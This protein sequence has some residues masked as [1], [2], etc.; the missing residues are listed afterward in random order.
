MSRVD[1]GTRENV[2][3]PSLK[4]RRIAMLRRTKIADRHRIAL[5]PPTT[6]FWGILGIV[7]IFVVLGIIMVLS[8]SSVVRLQSGGSAWDYFLR[9]ILW[10]SMGAGG[11]WYAYRIPYTT[12]V[13]Q[14][15]LSLAAVAVSVANVFVFAKGEFIKGAR[16]WLE[17]FGFRFQPS[18][19]MKIVAVLFCA[20]LIAKRHRSVAIPAMVHYPLVG[21]MCVTAGLC[22]LQR[23]Y[24][25]ALIFIGTIS[26]MMV[27]SGLSWRRITATLA[28][29]AVAGWLLLQVSTRARVRLTAFLNLDETK[30]DWGYQVYQ[31]LLSMANGG[32]TGTGIGSGTAKWGYVPEAHTDFIFAVIA[33]ELGL[34]GTVLVIGGFIFLVL[35]GVR[36]ALAAPDMTSALIA[37]GVS[38][39][40]GFQAFINIGG[41]SGTLP[42]TGLTLPFLSYGGSSL[43]ASMFA[44]GMLLKVARLVK[45]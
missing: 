19:F 8:S 2:R 24:G 10:A 7:S 9:Q 45:T 27:M 41:V 44:A 25:G 3:T 13:K 6:S 5:E 4:E 11:M 28:G 26:L 32:W 38:A 21:A 22:G 14:R 16:A 18:E 15:W 1:P 36:V 39:W 20:N 29:V 12:W 34:F 23:D 37:A 33:E 17:I 40:F 35:F 42:L 43:I 31:S 30:G